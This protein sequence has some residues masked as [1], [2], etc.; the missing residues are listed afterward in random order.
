MRKPVFRTDD[1]WRTFVIIELMVLRKAIFE[2]GILIAIIAVGAF[3]ARWW[4]DAPIT[5][6]AIALIGAISFYRYSAKDCRRL[7]DSHFAAEKD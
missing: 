5:G 4:Q 1:E 6:A 3:A 2:L 7:T